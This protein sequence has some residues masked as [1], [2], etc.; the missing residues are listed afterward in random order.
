MT[1]VDK[2]RHILAANAADPDAR[3]WSGALRP[4]GD[5]ATG[6]FIDWLPKATYPV[7]Y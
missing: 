3:R 7:R 6:L 4:L 1:N 5:A 2:W